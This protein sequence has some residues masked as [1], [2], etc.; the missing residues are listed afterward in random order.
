MNIIN[1]LEFTTA[2]TVQFDISFVLLCILFNVILTITILF[3]IMRLI[4]I[5]KERWQK[6]DEIYDTIKELYEKDNQKGE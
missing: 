6:Q 3:L 5:I 4:V 2:K 1:I